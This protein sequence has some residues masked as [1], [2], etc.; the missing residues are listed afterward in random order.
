MKGDEL[1]WLQLASHLK[2]SLDEVKSKTSASQFVLWMEYLKLEANLFDPT[3]MYLV[4]LTAEVR[5]SWVKSP[6]D[7]L[8]KDFVLKF[9]MDKS[10]E[11]KKESI[12]FTHT[13]KHSFFAL[14]GLLGRKKVKGK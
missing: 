10:L 8:V 13:L 2:M 5:R 9:D 7:V 11:E 3:R 14:T 6:K 12:A 1:G 4:A